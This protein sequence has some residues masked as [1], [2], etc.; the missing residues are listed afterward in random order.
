MDTV[1]VVLKEIWDCHQ[2]VLDALAGDKLVYY[3]MRVNG[4]WA[5]DGDGRPIVFGVHD[6]LHVAEMVILF[7]G[8]GVSMS[9]YPGT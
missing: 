6:P 3:G 9:P 2:D 4:D 7:R 8:D 1:D 5:R